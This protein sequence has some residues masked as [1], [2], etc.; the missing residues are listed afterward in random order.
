MQNFYVSGTLLTVVAII[1]VAALITVFA[2]TRKLMAVKERMQEIL[3]TLDDI[4][5][6]NN[7]RK[8]LVKPRDI[9][10]GICYKLNQIVLEHKRQ[11][12]EQKRAEEANKQLMT[13]LSHDVRTPLSSIMG[14][15]DAVHKGI[16]TGDERESYIESARSRAHDMKDYVDVLFE[17]FKLNSDEETFQMQP[18]ELTETTRDILKD[19][20]PV[21]E[22]HGFAYEIEIP[23]RSVPVILDVD[24]YTRILN[25]LMQNVMI[26][27]KASKVTISLTESHQKAVIFV[28]DNGHGILPADRPHIFDRLYK[29]DRARSAKGSGLGLS[30]TKQLVEKMK[31]SIEAESVPNQHTEFR[32]L[33]PLDNH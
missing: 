8:F 23:E 10:S 20:I 11:M 6:G 19:W 4:A 17:W 16:V 9:T 5:N 30:I 28:K 24:A 21:F 33:F 32:I 22:A 29:C 26:H 27:S 14:Y 2:L 3:E 15:L 12:V 7:D 1:A 13:S 18:I 31:G 25:N